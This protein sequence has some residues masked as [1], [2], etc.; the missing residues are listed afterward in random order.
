MLVHAYH[1]VGISIA[2]VEVRTTSA[3]CHLFSVLIAKNYLSLTQGWSI[4]S[5]PHCT[6]LGPTLFFPSS[7]DF[8]LPKKQRHQKKNKKDH[9]DRADPPPRDRPIVP[10]TR[11]PMPKFISHR[12]PPTLP[13]A[14]TNCRSQIYSAGSSASL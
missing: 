11:S 6:F 2:T 8:L 7:P 12:P 10:P 9:Y 5:K 1:L 3:L 13:C 14:P 4:S